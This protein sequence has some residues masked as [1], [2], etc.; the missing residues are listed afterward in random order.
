M[1]AIKPEAI[2]AHMA[3]L[4]DDV[5]E[6][7]LVGSRGFEIAAKYVAAQFEAMGLRPEGSRGSYMQPVPMRRADLVEAKCSASLVRDGKVQV[8]RIRDDYLPFKDGT[9]LAQA[10]DAPLVFVG[11]GVTAPE[12]GYDDYAGLDV[13]GKAVVTLDGAPPSFPDEVRGYYSDSLQVKP[14]NAA[15]HGAAAQIV[16]SPGRDQAKWMKYVGLD[17]PWFY[18]L[19]ASGNAEQPLPYMLRLSPNGKA[20]IFRGAA[21]TLDQALADAAKGAPNTFALPGSIRVRTAMRH[22]A[23]ASENVLGIM[24]GSDPALRD[25]Y[26]VLSTH[27]DHLGTGEPIDGDAIYN[28]AV[29]AASGVATVLTIARALSALSPPPKRS[30]LFLATTDEEFG[31]VGAEYFLRH[32]LVPLRDLVADVN[33]DEAM[34]ILF[35]T[36]DIVPYGAEHT[37]LGPLISDAAGRM[38]YGVGPDPIPEEAASVRFDHFSFMRAGVPAVTLLMESFHAADPRIDGGSIVRR[39]IETIYHS[40]KDDMRQEPLDFESAAKGARL[41]LALVYALAQAPTRPTWN[42]P[43]FF[44]DK[45]AK[46][47][48]P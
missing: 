21:K 35:E 8:L 48:G 37:G 46:A 44:G 10:T 2:R 43:D 7:R 12:Q 18:S 38:G 40:P 26:V 33:I 42:H 23:V 19:D 31:F 47:S 14:R 22:T 1:A 17:A 45:F 39:W 30:V 36:K 3:F 20:A 16:M 28:G 13:R 15:A 41:N 5:L 9:R 24:P 4:A 27:I 34:N 11:Y 25:E 6:G 32:P 29:D